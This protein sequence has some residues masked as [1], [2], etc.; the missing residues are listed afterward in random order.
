MP[1]YDDP[2]EPSQLDAQP[3]APAARGGLDWE[4]MRAKLATDDINLIRL[5]CLT[6]QADF[7]MVLEQLRMQP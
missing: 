3:L 7:D 2:S 6:H 1:G 4:Y 5:H